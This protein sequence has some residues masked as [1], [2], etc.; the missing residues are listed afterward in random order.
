MPPRNL[1][2]QL[3]HKLGKKIVQGELKPGHVLPK[4]EDVSTQEGVSRTVVREALKGLSARRLVESSTK[5]G[6]VV[7][8]RSEWQWWNPDVLAWAFQPDVDYAILL[9]L[10]EVRMAIE[11]SAV[12]LAAQ[13]ASDED[14]I[15][16]RECY[17]K[18]ENSLGSEEEWAAADFDFHN[19]ILI[20]S[21]NELMVSL[22]KTLHDALLQS[23][24]TSI[25]S[26]KHQNPYIEAN[27]EVILWHRGLMEAVCSRNGDEAYQKMSEL[28]HRVSQLLETSKQEV[29]KKESLNHTS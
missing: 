25:K 17:R 11:P 16:I 7:K 27:E 23:R 12:K 10:T 24:Q 26:L 2:E 13:N 29:S 5:T 4:V 15:R 8:D 21:H 9:Q 28:L 22:I 3:L 20:A 19:S 14:L 6:T 18:L 1:S